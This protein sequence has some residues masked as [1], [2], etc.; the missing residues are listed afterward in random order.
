MDYRKDMIAFEFIR[1]FAAK[2]IFDY[3]YEIVFDGVLKKEIKPD[4][5]IDIIDFVD[6][7]DKE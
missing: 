3:K 4:Q 6:N 5:I 7:Y 2:L 1:H